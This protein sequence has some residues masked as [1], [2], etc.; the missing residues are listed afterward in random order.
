M[1]CEN[2]YIKKWDPES[3]NKEHRDLK[4]ILSDEGWQWNEAKYAMQMAKIA[5]EDLL[6]AVAILFEMAEA[7]AEEEDE[8][9][10]ALRCIHLLF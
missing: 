2:S 10:D 4:W 3:E 1:S 6:E 7:E 8:K 9:E 5:K